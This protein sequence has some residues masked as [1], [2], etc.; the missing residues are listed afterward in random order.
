[1]IMEAFSPLDHR[2]GVKK[3]L[4]PLQ[5]DDVKLTELGD[6]GAVMCTAATDASEVAERLAGVVGCP[7]PMQHGETGMEADR[8]AI[9]MTP[10]SWLILCT[11]DDEYVIVDQIR[12]AFPD[13]LAHGAPF[14]DYLC[15]LSLAGVNAENLLR[16][17]GFLTLAPTGFPVGQAKR[18]MLAG[19]PAVILRDGSES[20]RIGVE[21]SRAAYFLNWLQTLTLS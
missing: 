15:W 20:W 1:M 17:G 10:R 4:P 2:A 14:G 11:P 3:P 13:H 18:T 21:R 7:L 6:G 8:Q 19:L 5:A 9:W 12:A 16:Q